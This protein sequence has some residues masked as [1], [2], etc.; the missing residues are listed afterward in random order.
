MPTLADLAHDERSA[1]MVLAIVD[2]PNHPSTGGL[3]TKSPCT[4]RIVCVLV[5]GPEYQAVNVPFFANAKPTQVLLGGVFG[6]VVLAECVQPIPDCAEENC[7]RSKAL[8][9]VDDLHPPTF[10]ISLSK[11]ES[12]HEVRRLLGSSSL[13]A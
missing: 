11:Q 8:L 12:A 1:R 6:E 13:K 3:L 5:S 9:T 7:C 4:D 10:I 2:E